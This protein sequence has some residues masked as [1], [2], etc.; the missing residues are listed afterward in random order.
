MATFSESVIAI[1]TSNKS[2][3]QKIENLV[4]LGLPTQE[5]ILVLGVYKAA[6]ATR[7]RCFKSVTFGVELECYNLRVY[8]FMPKVRE[9]GIVINNEGYNHRDS[10]EAF[11]IVPDSSIQG[12][13]SNEV[14]SPVLSG[15]DGLDKLK[16]VCDT[17]NEV[18]AKVNKSCGTH[19]HLDASKM[20]IEQWRNVYINYARLE[21]IIDSFMA[22]SRRGN[23]NCFCMSIALKER[24]E[25]SILSCNSV[26]DIIRLMRSRYYKIN[27]EAYRRHKTIEFRQHGGTISYEKISNWVNFL[28]K[29]LH[30]SKNHTVTNCA[31]IDDVPFLTQAE[32][33]YF[34]NRINELAA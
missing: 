5:A 13:N 33:R 7:E 29:L 16:K 10:K 2:R 26:D 30:Y 19:V 11:K 9:L 4:R 34:K 20:T 23:S 27:A 22:Q 15:K 31:T 21:H 18:G 8:D 25:T 28:Q 1:A 14:V 24:I 3:A 32:K 12:E 17:M 6:P